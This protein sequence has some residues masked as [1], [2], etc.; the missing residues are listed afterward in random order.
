M[1]FA[2]VS[3][4]TTS[5]DGRTETESWRAPEA[6]GDR[7]RLLLITVPWG[8]G[9]Q[10]GREQEFQ[11]AIRINGSLED[12]CRRACF[13]GRLLDNPGVSVPRQFALGDHA[14]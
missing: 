4:T 8:D 5:G 9:R 14:C 3:L 6:Q 10:T 2:W 13:F 1:G 12:A 11:I 7:S